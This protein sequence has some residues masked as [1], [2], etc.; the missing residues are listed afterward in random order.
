MFTSRCFKADMMRILRMVSRKPVQRGILAVKHALI[1]YCRSN[2][3]T[4]V[5][6]R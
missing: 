6:L 4:K 2:I 5:I 1:D 3:L